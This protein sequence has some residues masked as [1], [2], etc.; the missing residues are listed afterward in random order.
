MLTLKKVFII[1]LI[2][3]SALLCACSKE[4]GNYIDMS[5]KNVMVYN[6]DKK[7]PSIDISDK[8]A[9]VIHG[10]IYSPPSTGELPKGYMKDILNIVHFEGVNK[11]TGSDDT[12][13]FNV[14]KYKESSLLLIYDSEYWT[15]GCIYYNTPIELD[16]LKKSKTF[17]DVQKLDSTLTDNQIGLNELSSSLLFLRRG[18]QSNQDTDILNTT[19]HVTDNGLYWVSYDS[20]LYLV[21][22][23]E[24]KI[25]TIEKIEDKVY[26]TVYELLCKQ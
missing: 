13:Y 26:N 6:T 9:L 10:L 8:Q 18:Y 15:C 19:L 1:M 21:E 25:N 5:G 2:C 11:F 7:L 16:E 14:F 4:T 3:L 24:I 20:T 23:E 12:Y 22:S 17:K